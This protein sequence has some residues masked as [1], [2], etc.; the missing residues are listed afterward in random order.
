MWKQL[1]KS[2]QNQTSETNE[3][4]FL[5][6]FGTERI[7][8][9]HRSDG[10][11]YLPTE[12]GRFGVGVRDTRPSIPCLVGVR[13]LRGSESRPWSVVQSRLV[14]S[15]GVRVRAGTGTGKLWVMTTSGSINEGVVLLLWKWSASG[16]RIGVRSKTLRETFRKVAC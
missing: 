13:V 10:G 3:P 15:R 7:A 11:L 6:S 9:D 4:F 5:Y 2:R 8:T 16:I 1:A 14:V 12:F